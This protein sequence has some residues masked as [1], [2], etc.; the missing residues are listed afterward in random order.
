[1][2]S[3]KHT[4]LS[5]LTLDRNAT[6]V[7]GEEAS[8]YPCRSPEDIYRGPAPEHRQWQRTRHKFWIYESP[9]SSTSQDGKSNAS[10]EGNPTGSEGSEERRARTVSPYG[11]F[12]VEE[13]EF[14]IPTE[15]GSSLPGDRQESANVFTDMGRAFRPTQKPPST[16]MR[17]QAQVAP[18]LFVTGYPTRSRPLGAVPTPHHNAPGAMRVPLFPSYIDENSRRSQPPDSWRAGYLDRTCSPHRQNSQRDPPQAATALPPG[19]P[20]S[21]RN[22][23]QTRGMVHRRQRK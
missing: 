21:G 19:I 6:T 15:S 20:L 13:M 17:S 1:M 12:F 14:D 22:E 5:P 2:S 11:S 16:W 10:S 4:T 3:P 8:Q 7:I 9:P 18:V 23:R